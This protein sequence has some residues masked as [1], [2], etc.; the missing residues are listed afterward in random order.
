[1][2]QKAL[3]VFRECIPIFEVLRDSHRQNIIV[4]LCDRGELTVNEIAQQSSLSRPAISHHLKLLRAEGLIKVRQVGTQRFYSVS[5]QPSI[6]LLKELTKQ[7]EEVGEEREMKDD[8]R[9]DT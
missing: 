4:S 8:E 2:S 6:S 7:L 9:S 1:M 3:D 5:L